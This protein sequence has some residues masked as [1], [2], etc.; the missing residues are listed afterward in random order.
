MSVHVGQRGVTV[1]T[2]KQMKQQGEKIAC[3]TAYDAS[4]AALLDAAHVDVFLVGDSLGMVIQ[5]HDTT[6]PVTVDDMI[7]HG[8]AVARGARRALRIID[9]PFMSYSNPAQA[10]NN[11]ARLMQEGEAQMVKLEGGEIQVQ[12][13]GQL[14]AR[15]IPVCAHLGLQPQ[16]IYKLGGYR[17]Q[18]RDD[19]NAK[20][21][22]DTA[23]ELQAAGAEVLLVECIP[24]ALAARITAEVSIPVIGIG[25]GG[26]CDGQVLVLYD[27]LGI[28]LDR[29][30][31]FAH[32]FLAGANGIKDAIKNYVSAVKDQTFPG[33]EHS[34]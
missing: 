11:A 34:F 19:T 22:L 4:F 25:A 8:R 28:G 12:I 15:G 16:F 9:M 5:G 10:I 27:I 13:V 30:P 23:C 21:L 26:V 14:S 17:V 20:I 2:L 33:A 18:G 7:Y 3:L 29:A 6:V 31:R 1:S 32:N 24:A